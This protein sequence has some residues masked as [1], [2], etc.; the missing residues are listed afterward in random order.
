MW[1]VWDAPGSSGPFV[2]AYTGIGAGGQFITVLPALDMVVAHKTDI[3]QPSPHGPAKRR[4]AV[5]SGEYYAALHLLI[6]T[7]CPGPCP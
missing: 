6:A 3:S 1:W 4:R 2:G 7:R 5:S